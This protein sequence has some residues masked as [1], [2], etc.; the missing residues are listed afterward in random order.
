VYFSPIAV[1]LAGFFVGRSDA[2]FRKVAH[3]MVLLHFARH[4]LLMIR[5]L[6]LLISFIAILPISRAEI[7]VYAGTIQR[8]EPEESYKPVTLKCFIVTNPNTGEVSV[9]AYGKKDGIKRRDLGRTDPA[10][11]YPLLRL[12]GSKFDLYVYTLADKSMF[13]SQQRGLFL[14]GPQKSVVVDR[15]NGELVT[16]QR[17]RTLKG[18]IQTIGIGL[19]YSYL[20]DEIVVRLDEVRTVDVNVRDLTITQA[21]DEI[22]AFLLSLGFNL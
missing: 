15:Q 7:L 3:G 5:P 14:R 17:A 22:D 21:A 16:A 8:T 10:D 4:T 11:Y 19:G 20:E 2:Q 1:G 13:G 9:I 12:D 6:L 18:R